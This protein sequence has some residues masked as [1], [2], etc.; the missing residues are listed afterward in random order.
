MARISLVA[1]LFVLVVSLGRVA[2]GQEVHDLFQKG[3]VQERAEGNLEKAVE[4]FEQVVAKAED[5]PE[6]AAK[7]WLQIGACYERLGR[8]HQQEAKKAYQQGNRSRS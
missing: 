2:G 6:L 7:A 5:N 4:L 3:L 1:A 8:Q